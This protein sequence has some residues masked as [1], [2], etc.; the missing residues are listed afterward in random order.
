MSG[1]ADRIDVEM[2]DATVVVRG[3]LDAFSAAQLSDALAPRLTGETLVLDLRAVTFIDSRGLAALLQ[4]HRN[5]EQS[6]GAVQ[7]IASRRVRRLFEI[8]GLDGYLRIDE[9]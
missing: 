2:S 6:G 1:T 7:M 3:E 9:G 4:V 5:A 8:A